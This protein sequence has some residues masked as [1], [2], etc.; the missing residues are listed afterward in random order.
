MTYRKHLARFIILLCFT[1]LMHGFCLAA[2]KADSSP[3]ILVQPQS[4][5]VPDGSTAS[6]SIT[7]TGTGLTYQWYRKSFT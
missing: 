4:V 6:V 1:F 7:A 3:V 5:M 2:A